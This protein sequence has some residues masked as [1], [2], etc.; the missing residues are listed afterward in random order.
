L[1]KLK[2][3]AT[4]APKVAPPPRPLGKHGAKLWESVNLEFKIDDAGGV[5]LLLSACQALDRAESC[6]EQIDA[7][8]EVISTKTGIREHPLIKAELANRAFVAR[9]IQ[10]LGLDVE[11]VKAIGRP[12]SP[13]GWKGDK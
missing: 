13:L 6:R 1:S 11:A 3:V 5:E 4:A 9:S 7:V 2:L 8:G 12:P 10:R